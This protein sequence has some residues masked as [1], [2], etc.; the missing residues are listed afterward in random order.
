MDKSKFH[1]HAYFFIGFLRFLQMINIH[2]LIV[3]VSHSGPFSFPLSS[4]SQVYPTHP[5]TTLCQTSPLCSELLCVHSYFCALST[6]F[7]G[8]PTKT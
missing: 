6:S 2:Y 5:G 4:G 7:M 8:E 1:L 3:A